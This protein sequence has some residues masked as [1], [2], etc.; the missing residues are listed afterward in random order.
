MPSP[1]KASD[2]SCAMTSVSM[3]DIRSIIDFERF[4]PWSC[5]RPLCAEDVRSAQSFL[6][7][8]ERGT[9]FDTYDY[10]Y[11]VRRTAML[12]QE[13]DSWTNGHQEHPIHIDL[14]VLSCVPNRGWPVPDGNHRLFAAHITDQPVVSALVTG[15]PEQVER[16]LPRSA[17]SFRSDQTA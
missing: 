6:D 11:H 15:T 3:G 2:V 14:S 17:W 1:H 10:N 8:A 7:F 16:W 12:V 9:L 4:D 13:M 5:H